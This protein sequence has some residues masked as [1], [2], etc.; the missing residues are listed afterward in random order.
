MRRILS[1]L[2]VCLSAGAIYAQVDNRADDVIH[3]Q[4]D[5]EARFSDYQGKEVRFEDRLSGDLYIRSISPQNIQMDVVESILWHILMLR[6]GGGLGYN[7]ELVNNI[8]SPGL[9][10]DL[11][12]SPLFLLLAGLSDDETE[13]E[14]KETD[15]DT[16]PF[17]DIGLRINNRF[18]W[19]NIDIRPF[20]GISLYND[21]YLFHQFGLSL[22][23][24]EHIGLEYAYLSNIF[25][26][27]LTVHRITVLW[28][29]K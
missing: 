16:P 12:I 8:L 29:I 15:E 22:G 9:Y 17:F 21:G 10:F 6:I 4:V 5:D 14:T 1:V 27:K 23:I 28:N 24:K 25:R 3:S 7:Y 13:E 26:E 19:N 20:Y 2:I 18:L 11:G